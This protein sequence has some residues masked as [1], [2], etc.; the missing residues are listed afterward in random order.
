M[1]LTSSS[2]SLLV[3][4][5]FAG[6]HKVCDKRVAGWQMAGREVSVANGSTTMR[7][8][9]MQL[10]CIDLQCQTACLP[11]IFSTP[12]KVIDFTMILTYHHCLIIIYPTG[13]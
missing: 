8:M 1:R 4:R 6:N 9:L 3:P 10:L 11:L 5:H 7:L 2:V 13:K 12:D